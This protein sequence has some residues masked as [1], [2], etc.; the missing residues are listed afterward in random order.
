MLISLPLLTTGIVIGGGSWGVKKYRDQRKPLTLAQKL[1][2]TKLKWPAS[3]PARPDYRKQAKLLL[4]QVDDRYQELIH[5]TIDQVFGQHYET[6][7]QTLGGASEHQ[8]ARPL[9]KQRNRQM[10]YAVVSLA[11]V[12]TGKPLLVAGSFAINL[13]LISALIEIGAKDMQKKRQLTSRGRRSFLQVGLLL[14]GYLVLQSIVQVRNFFFEKLLLMVQSQSRNTL[15]K[16]FGELPKR[17]SRVQDGQIVECALEM[18]EA[19]D[20]LVVRAGEVIPMDGEIIA[21][22]ASID[23]HTLTGEAQPVEKETGDTVF[24]STIL[25]M[26]EIRIEVTRANAETLAAQIT[27]IL[28]H[29][30]SQ[31]TQIG[32]KG[33]EIADR[34]VYIAM[35]LGLVA[36]PIWGVSSMLA[37]WA[38]PVGAILMETTPLMSYLDMSARSNILIKDGRSLDL[39]SGIDTVVFDKTGTLTMEQPTVCGVHQ[40]GDLSENKLLALAAAIEQHQS[41]PIAAAIREA[42]VEQDLTLPEVNETHIE[43]GYGLA[44]TLKNEQG[45]NQRTQLGSQRYMTLSGVSIPTEMEQLATEQQLMGHSMVYLAVNGILQGMIELKPTVRPEAQKVVDALHKR[46]LTLVMITGDQEVP[47]QVLADS[48]QIDQVFANVLPEQ[49]AQLV[50]GLQE[51]GRRV[52]FVG[53]GIND[54]IA[55]K[56]AHV[57]VS[58]MGATTVATDTA[59]IVL[60]DGSLQQLDLLFKLAEHYDHHMK[61]QYALGVYAPVI[62]MGLIFLLGWGIIT[63]YITGTMISLVN[64][65]SALRPTWGQEQLEA[66]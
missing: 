56:Q 1:S 20:V 29:T 61:R 37:L 14:N 26:G 22:H 60:M 58:I 55:L 32:L 21:G 28:N 64:F 53:D 27:D 24:A 15:V 19:G 8:A 65:G 12:L 38:V 40:C 3:A 47:A 18:V 34:W 62:H 7:M 44:V 5:N 45:E 42:A 33:I 36:L 39:L 6:H 9:V 23:Q 31:H 16:V 30:Q 59:Q 17:V 2:K 52:M 43:V 10:G 51:Q 35:G 11:F 41:H 25:L 46:G 66:G 4:K 49:K 48:L 50:R 13:Y 57:S 54:S 63:T